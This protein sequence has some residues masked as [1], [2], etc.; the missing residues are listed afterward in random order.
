MFWLLI[1]NKVIKGSGWLL[2]LVY[3]LAHFCTAVSDKDGAVVVDVYEST[4]L[5][6]EDGCEGDAEFR[7]DQGEPT[8]LPFRGFVESGNF[9]AARGVRRFFVDLL[10]H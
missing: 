8:F 4:G 1:E 5:I 10:V 2:Y 7:R 6:E 3:L 9:C